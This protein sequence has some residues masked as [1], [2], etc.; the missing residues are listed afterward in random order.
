MQFGKLRVVEEGLKLIHRIPV[1]DELVLLRAAGQCRLPV[2]LDHQVVIDTSEAAATA[3][4]HEH[5]RRSC[6]GAP[7]QPP[8]HN[9]DDG[10][11]D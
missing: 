9:Q 11:E 4:L 6:S 1:E 10:D 3:I 5:F 7:D 2:L 8:R